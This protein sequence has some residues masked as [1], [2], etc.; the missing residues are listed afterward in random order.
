VEGVVTP[1]AHADAYRGKRVLLTGHTGFKGAWLAEWL[2]SLDADVRGLALPPPTQ[3]S[4]FEQLHL[5]KRLDHRVG[6]IVDPAVVREV[7]RA[8]RP[9]FVFH[10]AA[11]S[12]VRVSYAQPRE[13]FATNVMGTVNVLEAVRLYG[14]RRDLGQVLRES[15][16]A[17]RLS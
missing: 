14:G 8:A 12:L 7:V 3:P 13:T 1:I 9:D 16:V 5:E 2:L 10:L 11:Q 17:V 4:L 6:D 15:R